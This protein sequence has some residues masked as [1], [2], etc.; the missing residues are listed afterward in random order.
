MP[1]ATTEAPP[2]LAAR[3]RVPDRTVP[4]VLVERIRRRDPHLWEAAY[5]RLYPRLHGFAARRVSAGQAKDVVAETMARAIAAAERFEPGD[6]AGRVDASDETAAVADAFDAWVFG[7]CRHVVL[8]VQR[9][10][11]RAA[12]RAPKSD[13]IPD[14]EH[15]ARL[16][17]G[18]EGD[19][20]RIA[21]ARLS[22]SDRELLDLRIVGGLSAEQVAAVLGMKAGAVR[23]AQARALDRL[24][25][26]FLEVHGAND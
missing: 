11:R 8:D 2:V 22:D 19:A 24:R 14:G 6:R 13:P 1:T 20:V 4:H 26:I 21:Y 23:M 3:R 25:R 10:G 18:E 7:I 17:A 12:G 15:G 9:A 16:E 5:L